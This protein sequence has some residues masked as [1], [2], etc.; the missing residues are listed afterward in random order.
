MNRDIKSMDLPE[1]TEA[2]AELGEPKFRAKQLFTW[3]HR[4][5]RTFDE[6]TNLQG[7]AGEA[8]DA[9]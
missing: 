2:L 5:A 9:V 7:P 1:L 6:M 4:G 3:L 8:A